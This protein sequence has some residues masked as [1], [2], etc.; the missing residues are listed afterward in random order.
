M[1]GKYFLVK[2]KKY[3]I[4]KKSSGF[5]FLKRLFF[6]VAKDFFIHVLK[7]IWVSK[8]STIPHRF[9]MVLTIMMSTVRRLTIYYSFGFDST[10]GTLSEH[11]VWNTIFSAFTRCSGFVFS[12]NGISQKGNSAH[13]HWREYK[14]HSMWPVILFWPIGHRLQ[15]FYRLPVDFRTISFPFFSANHLGF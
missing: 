15:G 5:F 3:T 4:N 6:D 10:G 13:L 7:S 8:F 12:S 2:S 14:I 9:M 11:M 1:L